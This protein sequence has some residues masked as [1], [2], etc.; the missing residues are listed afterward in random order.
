[1]IKVFGAVYDEN[2]NELDAVRLIERGRLAHR[3]ITSMQLVI[4]GYALGAPDNAPIGLI[5]S[6]IDEY[7]QNYPEEK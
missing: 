3:I 1:M 4:A 5:H 2:D 6:A 7:L